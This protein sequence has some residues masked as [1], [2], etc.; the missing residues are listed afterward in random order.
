MA[1]YIIIILLIILLIIW[2]K[3]IIYKNPKMYNK[4]GYNKF[5]DIIINYNGNTFNNNRKEKAINYLIK[6]NIPNITNE[7][8]NVIKTYLNRLYD[9]EIYVLFTSNDN[10]LDIIFQRILNNPKHFL[11]YLI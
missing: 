11:Y 1:Y 3:N 8:L 6:Y 9:F 10:R 5:E 4:I 2:W 7:Y